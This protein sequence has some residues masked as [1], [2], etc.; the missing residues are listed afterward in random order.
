ML[1]TSLAGDSVR[2]R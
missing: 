1:Y 2:T